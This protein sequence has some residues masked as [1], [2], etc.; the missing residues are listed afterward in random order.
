MGGELINLRPPPNKMYPGARSIKAEIIRDQPM[1][2]E[3]FGGRNQYAKTIPN[4]T[5]R[6]TGVEPL[7]PDEP[8]KPR[9][10]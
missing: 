2:R 10:P 3:A 1:T 5:L 7:K 4:K 8:T 6:R 9:E